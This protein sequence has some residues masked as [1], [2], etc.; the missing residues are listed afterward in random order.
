MIFPKNGN[1]RVNSFSSEFDVTN[2]V[3]NFCFFSSFLCD[4][5]IVNCQLIRWCHQILWHSTCL[6]QVLL[7]WCTL[8]PIISRYSSRLGRIVVQLLPITSIIGWFWVHALVFTHKLASLRHSVSLAWNLVVITGNILPFTAR[9]VKLWDRLADLA[10]RSLHR[11]T[12]FNWRLV[13]VDLAWVF[14]V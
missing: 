5:V 2:L 8:W 12:S 3:H 13:C 7:R 6:C 10:G 14:F 11:D 4:L 9:I 1:L